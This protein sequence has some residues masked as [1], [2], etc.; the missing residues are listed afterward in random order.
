MRRIFILMF[1]G[2]VVNQ[3]SFGQLTGNKSIPGNYPTVAAAI[4]DLNTQG[5]GPGGVTF[6][7]SAGYTETFTDALDGQITTQT[8]SLSSPIV[9]KKNGAGAN[10]VITS[11]YGS[12]NYDFIFELCGTDYVTFDG[13][14]VTDDPAHTDSFSQA[15]YGFALMKNPSDTSGTQY[16]TI[17]HCT[18]LL[19][20]SNSST[21]G[22]NSQ[23]W[24]YTSMGS[25]KILKN[26]RQTNSYNSFQGNT[27]NHCFTGINLL[28]YSLTSLNNQNTDIGSV[29]GNL[30]T[31]FG[32]TSGTA[33]GIYAQYENNMTVANN[34]ITGTVSGFSCNG[35]QFQGT[36]NASVYVYGNT[37]TIQFLGTGSFYGIKDWMGNATA[38]SSTVYHD[39]IITG[40]TFPNA[41]SSTCNYIEIGHG[42]PTCSFY[43]NSVTNNTYGS[44]STTSS[45]PIICMSVGGYP[46]LLGT[47]DVY[48]N[49]VSGNVRVQS[50]SGS[51]GNTDYID[52]GFQ[53]NLL[54]C[55][56]NVIDN[57]TSTTTGA[58][59]GLVCRAL[60]PITKNIYG[61]TITNLNNANGTTYG[62]YVND[63]YNYNIYKNKI[64]NI[65]GS[66]SSTMI[67]G[68]YIGFL[69]GAG[70]INIFNNFIGDL[71]AGGS[72][73]GTAITGMWIFGG[74]EASMTGI[75]N[76]TIYINSTSIGA[77]FGTAGLSLSHYNKVLDLRNNIVVNT[78]TPNGTGKTLAVLTDTLN[79]A[80]LSITSNNNNYYAGTPSSKNLIFYD[81]VTGDSSL[82]RYKTRMYPRE[83]LSV[84]ENPPF[85]SILTPAD[86]RI[87]ATEATQCES[88]GSIVAVPMSIS[89]DYFGN[90]RFP[91][92][93]YPV[94][95]SYPAGAPD[96]G[97]HEFGGIPNDNTPPVISYS[98]FAN[99]ATTS[100]RVLTATVTDVHGV[101]VTGIGLP[102]AC[103][104]KNYTGA[105]TYITGTSTGN[106]Q[107][108]FNFNPGAALG[109]TIYYFLVAQDMWSVPNVGP[110]PFSGASGYSANPPS[111]TTPPV[112]PNK[113][114]IVSPICGTFN[115]GSGGTYSTLTAAFNDINAKGITC[116]VTLV[117]TDNT[118]Y[119]ESFPLTLQ[120]N[121]GSSSTNTLTIKPKAGVH[122]YIAG[123]VPSGGLLK[124]NGFDHLIIDGA[125]SGGTE[126]MI[127]WYNAGEATGAFVIMLANKD[128][129]DPA[130]NV[131][132]K[133]C[134]V[135]GVS[136]ATA[137]NYGIL[138]N[139]SGGGY[140]DINIT[141]DSIY[142]VHTGIQFTGNFSGINHNGQITNNVI[143]SSSYFDY[144]T[145]RGILL[146]Y[147]DNTLISGNNIM[148]CVTGNSMP[149]QAGVYVLNGSTNT[150]I[151]KNLIHDFYR[152]SDDG[153]GAY[154]IWYEA[155]NTSVTE[156]SNNSIYGIKSSGAAPG[157]APNNCYGIY[158]MSGG[159]LKILHNS[160]Y[161]YGDILSPESYRTGSSACLGIYQI[162]ALT[163]NIE[164]RNN[165][166]KNS[167]KVLS[168][169][170]CGI[171]GRAYGI[172]TTANDPGNFSVIDYND[173]FIDGCQ[174]S[175]AYT[176]SNKYE[177]LTN[178][179]TFTS[180]EVHSLN[181][182]P[183]FTSESNL[184]PTTTGMPKTGSY[185]TSL[186]TDIMGA[187]RTNP[188]DMGAYEFTTSPLVVTTAATNILGA[189]AILHGSANAVSQNMN[190]FFDYGTTSSYG[191]VISGSPATISGGT[192][193]PVSGSLAGLVANTVYHFRLRGVTFNNVTVYGND[194]TFTTPNTVPEN[195]I[196]GGVVT[197]SNDTCFNATN[198]ITVAGTPNTFTVLSGGSATFIAGVKIS[199]LP[200][201]TVNSGGYMH[202]YISAGPYCNGAILS[203]AMV[204]FTTETTPRQMDLA[205]FSIYPNPTSGNFILVQKGDFLFSDVKLEV[206]SIHGEK[207]MTGVMIG[208]K[209]HEFGFS[210]LP[211]GLYFV[212]IVADGYAETIKLVKL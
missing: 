137:I 24:I 81:G 100:P 168:G 123:Y 10:P 21:C 208:E 185:I 162:S 209:K 41:T 1:I 94:N 138:L 64:Q 72:T 36:S 175:I 84:T 25:N 108:T 172:M 170:P 65:N 197:I 60:R 145:D 111:V 91:N 176:N 16:A 158:V 128:G 192:T 201:T 154:G 50:P 20:N 164:F 93:G 169:Q 104:K 183:V 61:N 184:I 101:P 117:L 5:A 121:G 142:A 39:N 204:A 67:Y 79:F 186:P 95:P 119:T 110:I 59:R 71:K 166:L 153:S 212:R 40:C 86:L 98:P 131:T 134:I 8:G 43:N 200:G 57:N 144:V 181:I 53:C 109:D 22:I 73:S 92:A 199:Y 49:T 63:G 44:T 136:S 113:Y 151:R 155:E 90:A 171:S 211:T 125:P 156:I 191:S 203:P 107:Y 27:I 17:K 29:E 126:K 195:N 112:A 77:N 140:D 180:Q 19:N 3:I 198:T 173:Y 51:G 38:A 13:I 174:G 85:N 205:G 54:N 66:S 196:I 159:N 2:L 160:I 210:A 194:M 202:G 35:M 4:A 6:N 161:L 18:I 34:T 89:D 178:W 14:D 99:I 69:G 149:L 88:G 115:V 102:R 74:Y 97:A 135:K 76:N 207:V 105:W 52:I 165:I 129:V 55:Y 78:S 83:Y 96:I 28:G 190:M 163:N 132:I 75:Y 122:P 56:G 189:S 127:T 46:S 147:S 103:W 150:K 11:A 62:L 130:T 188:P 26:L 68:M 177:L 141:D 167:Q 33:N 114:V 80:N 30:I 42:A 143:G 139:S 182:N 48:N 206:Y 87:S 106:N 116:P 15:E 70:N 124:V 120:P 157:A 118:Y 31:N 9:F 12:G 37:V 58:A 146:Q 82:L 23:N 32:G 152:N 193:Q 133:N 187:T 47:L 148:G 179:Q 7:I 45:G